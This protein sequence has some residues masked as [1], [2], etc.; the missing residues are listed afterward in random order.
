[1]NKTGPE[2][3]AEH[4]ELYLMID[5]ETG[6]LNE[7]AIDMFERWGMD[8][9]QKLEAYWHRIIMLESKRTLAVA[10]RDAAA[11]SVRLIDSEIASMKRYAAN[12]LVMKDELGENTNI[13]GIGWGCSLRRTVSVE[14][15]KDAVL[16]EQYMRVKHV[17]SPDKTKIKEDLNR[18]GEIEGAR[19]VDKPSVSWKRGGKS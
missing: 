15:D 18:G 16:G 11:H 5:E 7:Q 10:K 6:E 12:L 4:A 17:A 2:L 9:D 14:V 3:W 13:K 8:A 19:L 1:M